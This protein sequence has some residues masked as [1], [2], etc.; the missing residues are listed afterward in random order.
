MIRAE[1]C[2]ALRPERLALPDALSR[3]QPG[4]T[5][6]TASA[7]WIWKKVPEGERPDVRVVPSHAGTAALFA[8]QER[9]IG[10]LYAA[11]ELPLEY[12]R[13]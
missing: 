5:V 3:I 7:E 10:R 2:E 8:Y 9:R 11:R 4:Q 12:P 13:T 1:R 6:V